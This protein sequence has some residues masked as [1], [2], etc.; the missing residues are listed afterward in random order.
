M[1]QQML[2][3]L[4]VFFVALAALFGAVAWLILSRSSKGSRRL[5]ELSR[6]RTVTGL[7]VDDE[8]EV[9]EQRLVEYQG[10]VSAGGKPLF[11]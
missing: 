1:T 11:L 4:G 8:M 5:S 2:T 9:L 10:T 6:P 7:I 3:T